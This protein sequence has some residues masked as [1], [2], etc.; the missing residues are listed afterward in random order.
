MN[1]L[2]DL[3]NEDLV[4]LPEESSAPVAPAFVKQIERRQAG[5][6]GHL[7]GTALCPE[8]VMAG[9]SAASSARL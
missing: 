5:R 1:R 6:I 3:R 9:D 8:I 4:M 7:P 2:K